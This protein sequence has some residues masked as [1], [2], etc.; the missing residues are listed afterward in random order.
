MDTPA[1]PGSRE[2]P[3]LRHF[4][5]LSSYCARS[6]STALSPSPAGLMPYKEDDPT[7]SHWSL[8]FSPSPYSTFSAPTHL[9]LEEKLHGESEP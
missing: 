1:C 2:P 8:W 7:V 9:L 6:N 4:V 5:S 3:D